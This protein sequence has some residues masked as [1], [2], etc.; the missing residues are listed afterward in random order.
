VTT[1]DFDMSGE[2]ANWSGPITLTI[3]RGRYGGYSSLAAGPALQNDQWNI[4]WISY[5]N[6]SN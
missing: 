6:L 1:K 3:K 4:N 5:R 2:G